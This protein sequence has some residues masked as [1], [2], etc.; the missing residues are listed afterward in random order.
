MNIGRLQK[1]RGTSETSENVTRVLFQWAKGPV[2]LTSNLTTW[3]WSN[4]FNSTTCAQWFEKKLE[5]VEWPLESGVFYSFTIQQISWPS[6]AFEYVSNGWNN[7]ALKMTTCDVFSESDWPSAIVCVT[8]RYFQMAIL[9]EGAEL[10]APIAIFAS[11]YC[12]YRFCLFSLRVWV[13]CKEKRLCI[14]SPST[15]NTKTS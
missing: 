4:R 7:K 12:C 8:T 13:E 3:N 1:S 5:I 9:E 6:G 15:H 14:V 11:F 2:S 10:H